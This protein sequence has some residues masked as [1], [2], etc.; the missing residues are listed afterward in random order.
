MAG[1]GCQLDHIWNLEPKCLVCLGGIW[2]FL[3]WFYLLIIVL[4]VWLFCLHVCL[5]T[6][7]MPGDHRGHKKT[8]NWNWRQLRAP[9]ECWEANWGPPEEPSVSLN[10]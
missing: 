10:L 8:L 1:L 4:H 3:Q 6:A 2:F 9:R 5:C 7:G